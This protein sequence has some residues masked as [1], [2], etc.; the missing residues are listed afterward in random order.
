[1]NNHDKLKNF[2]VVNYPVVYDATPER[3]AFMVDQLAKYGLQGNPYVTKR[4][5][6]FKDNVIVN[7]DLDIYT[8]QPGIS[9]SFLNMMNLWYNRGEEEIGLFCD[10]DS[11]FESIDNWN[12]T[13]QEFIDHLPPN[14]ECVQLIRCNDWHFGFWK[15]YRQ[16]IPSLKLRLRN[17]DDWGSS[18]I[19]KRSY[20]KKI[21]DRHYV[22]GTTYNFN[23]PDP[24]WG[25]LW[26]AVENM[27]YLRDE[28]VYS[29]PM[30][31]E[32]IYL[33]SSKD[34]NAPISANDENHTHTLSYKYYAR[35]WN[36]PIV[37][38]HVDFLMKLEE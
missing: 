15:Y 10:D 14:W 6:E 29:F 23:V 31:L 2:P 18:F 37:A 35:L 26:P 5:S 27:L 8:G 19:C 7:S 25:L 21:L 4:F 38:K 34:P 3:K 9:I 24:T 1:V 36:D 17:W 16:E 32:N 30:I 20:A 33:T 28:T 12:F 13:W 11:S 22:D